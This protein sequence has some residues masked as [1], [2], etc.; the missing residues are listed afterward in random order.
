LTWSDL[1]L[2]QPELV[3]K[4]TKELSQFRI[5][6]TIQK[7]FLGKQFE[8]FYQMAQQTDN[9][10]LGAVKAQE[11]KQTKGLENLEKR[12]LKAEKRQHSQTLERIVDLQ[13]NLFPNKSLQERQANFSEFYLE[14]GNGLIEKLMQELKPLENNFNILEL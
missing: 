4:K 5:D 1:F 12:L 3:I 9:S 13:N 11:A 8:D 2:R 14:Y 10:F 7:E 6:F